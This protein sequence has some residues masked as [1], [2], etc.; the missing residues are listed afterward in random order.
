MSCFDGR[1]IPV[2]DPIAAAVETSMDWQL[3]STTV[4]P[5]ATSFATKVCG[6][7]VHG[8]QNRVWVVAHSPVRPGEVGL[9]GRTGGVGEGVCGEE[10]D[11][12]QL[13]RYPDFPDPGDDVLEAL[14]ATCVRELEVHV[15]VGLECQVLRLETEPEVAGR[16]RRGREQLVLEW[17][18]RPAS[19]RGCAWN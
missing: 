4:T 12:G 18:Q 16:A 11:V 1:Q 8:I 15:G 7:V 13:G 6:Q 14:V 5:V 9:S 19:I 3:W 17:G 2:S 10:H